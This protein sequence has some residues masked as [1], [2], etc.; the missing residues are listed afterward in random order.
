MDVGLWS[1]REIKGWEGKGNCGF[2]IVDCRDRGAGADGRKG[3]AFPH[4]W[5]SVA[6][7]GSAWPSFAKASEA[8]PVDPHRD[9][10]WFFWT[11]MNPPLYAI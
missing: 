9:A 11:R 3:G 6:V 2:W 7:R 5:E 10:A 4:D 8:I 1:S